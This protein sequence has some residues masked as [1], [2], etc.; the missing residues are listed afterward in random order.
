MVGIVDDDDKLALPVTWDPAHLL[1]LAVTDVRDS[2]SQSG[3]FFKLFIKRCNIFNQLL[4]HGKG[5]AFLK[6]IDD[7]AMRPISYAAQRFT[8]SSYDQWIKIFKSYSSFIEAFEALHPNRKENEEWQYMIMGSDFV[9]DLLAMI[10]IMK[11]LVDLMLEM[12]ALDSPIWKL[13]KNWPK[14]QEKLREAGN[15]YLK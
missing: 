9:Q 10:D 12:Q 8:S 2:D 3:R 11:P 15:T 7:K 5:F 4:S 1:N 13:K 14:L 6:M